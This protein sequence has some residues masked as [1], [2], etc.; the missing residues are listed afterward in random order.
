MESPENIRNK[1]GRNSPILSHRADPMFHI[2]TLTH[3]FVNTAGSL[4]PLAS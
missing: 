3:A 1:F 2:D 4:S